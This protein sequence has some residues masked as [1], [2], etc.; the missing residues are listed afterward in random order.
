M[1]FKRLVIIPAAIAAC[2]LVSACSYHKT[3]DNTTPSPVVESAPAPVVET[4]PAPAPMSSTTTT[5][6][7]NNGMVERQR[8]TTVTPGY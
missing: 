2:G 8:T 7:D 6:T 5:T 1:R 4:A 3:V